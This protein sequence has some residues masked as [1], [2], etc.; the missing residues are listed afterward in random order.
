VLTGGLFRQK[1]D[2][3]QPP[4]KIA[5]RGQRSRS[6]VL[7]SGDAVDTCCCCCVEH[8]VVLVRIFFVH[9]FDLILSI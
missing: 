2:H 6:S 8:H 4:V 7:T 1:R 9:F 5:L 3:A